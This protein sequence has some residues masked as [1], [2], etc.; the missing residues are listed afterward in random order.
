MRLLAITLVAFA[1]CSA[2]KK[3]INTKNISISLTKMQCGSYEVKNNESTIGYAVKPFI[4]EVDRSN[5][6]T[7]FEN[8]I[9]NNYTNRYNNLFRIYLFTKNRIGDT[10]LNVIMIKPKQASLIPGWQCE[11]QDVDTYWSNHTKNP[12]IIPY[13]CTKER[14]KI[15]GD[16]D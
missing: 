9:K 12:Q 6:I 8:L 7:K 16:P 3:I 11:E 1:S 14:F 10:I 2:S 13:N 15:W 4:I 5:E